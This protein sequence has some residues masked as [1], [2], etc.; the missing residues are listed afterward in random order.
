MSLYDPAEVH[1][2][3]ITRKNERRKEGGPLPVALASSGTH[4]HHRPQGG[5]GVDSP[6]W[7]LGA[8]GSLPPAWLGGCPGPPTPRGAHSWPMLSC[9]S[10]LIYYLQSIARSLKLSNQQLRMQIQNASIASSLLCHVCQSHDRSGQ[11]GNT[12]EVPFSNYNDSWLPWGHKALPPPGFTEL[13]LR[14]PRDSSYLLRN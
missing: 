3:E 2:R 11:Q 1:I 12:G 10:M 9:S 7:D 4:S 5:V 14:I 8:S 6:T 13:F